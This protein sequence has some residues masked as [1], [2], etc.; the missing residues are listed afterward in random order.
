MTPTI[1]AA[2]MADIQELARLR[3]QLYTEY[4]PSIA[5]PFDAYRERFVP[6]A[7]DALANE[8]PWRAWAAEE[9][10]RLVGAMWLQT[11]PR[12]PAPGRSDPR[13]IGYLTN[14][15]VE[16]AFRGQ[17]LGSTMLAAVLEHCET[18]GFELIVAWPADDAYGFYERAGFTRP[19][20]PVVRQLPKRGSSEEQ[21]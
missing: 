15:Y 3:F 2:S 18:H 12:V 4:T 5:E 10:G 16:P 21:P 19:P 14:A 17:G 20:D 9:D 6:F 7:G 11:V 13:P 8:E 1:R